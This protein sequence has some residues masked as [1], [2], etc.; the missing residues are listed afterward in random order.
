MNYNEYAFIASEITQLEHMLGKMP[1]DHKVQ[2]IGLEHRLKRANEKLHGVQR[3]PMPR[4]T[5]VSLLQTHVNNVNPGMDVYLAGLSMEA[6]AQALQ[7]TLRA[8]TGTEPG[9]CLITDVTT[10]PPGFEI[11]LP[12]AEDQWFI[13][14]GET[15]AEQAINAL[16]HLAEALLADDNNDLQ[17][18]AEACGPEAAG[19]LSEI[20][21]FLL[22]YE[23]QANI[24]LN[25]RQVSLGDNAGMTNAL[26]RLQDLARS[27]ATQ[28]KN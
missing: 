4:T 20:L 3:P 13:P 1:E 7:A 27:K 11:Q 24:Y 19:K 16:Q 5:L 23:A 25:G 21:R 18:A 6:F 9:Q 8:R 22:E 26:A 14:M 28:Q 15:D 12:V 17:R 2:R 10:H